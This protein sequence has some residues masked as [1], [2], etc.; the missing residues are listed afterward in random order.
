MIKGVGIGFLWRETLILLGM[1]LFFLA[2][3]LKNF[4]D[5]LE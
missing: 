5:R 4:K 2:L 1:G 3:S